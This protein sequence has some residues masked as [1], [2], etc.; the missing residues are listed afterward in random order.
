[1]LT[2]DQKLDREDLAYARK[3]D[4]RTQKERLEEIVPRTDPGSR[5]RQLEKKREVTATHAS[6]RD[7]KEAGVEDVPESDLLGDDGADGFK[8]RKKEMEKKKT[9]RELRKE[10]V[11]RARAEERQERLTARKEKEDKTMEMFKALAKQKFG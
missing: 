7:E 9:E 8:R 5:E 11:W 4:R 6:F 10:E 2:E 3:Q 1:M